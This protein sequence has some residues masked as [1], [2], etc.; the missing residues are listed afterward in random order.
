M[1]SNWR[2]NSV[3]VKR[4][5]M[6]VQAMNLRRRQRGMTFWMLLFV[7]GVLGFAFY[8]TLKLFPI[9]LESFK[10]DRIIESVTREPGIGDQSRTAIVDTL[11]KRFDIDDVRRITER[12]FKNY[13]DIDKKGRR[14]RITVEYRAEAHLAGNIYL[15][16]NF[17]KRASN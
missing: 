2:L 4:G 10:I 3:D 6:G 8:V 7:L 1:E 14:V 9:Y 12:N 13:V 17:K 15:V 16:A 5:E 11:V